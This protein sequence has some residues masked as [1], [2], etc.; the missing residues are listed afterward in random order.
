MCVHL[1]F[2][3]LW[4]GNAQGH[5][6]HFDLPIALP[7]SFGIDLLHESILECIL[8]HTDFSPALMTGLD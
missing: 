8:G 7:F 5:T 6:I 4:I 2:Y 3:S 1:R